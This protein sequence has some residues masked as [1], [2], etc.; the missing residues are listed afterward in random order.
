MRYSEKVCFRSRVIWKPADRGLKPIP[1]TFLYLNPGKPGVEARRRGFVR[2][3]NKPDTYRPHGSR[4]RSSGLL[5]LVEKSFLPF[6]LEIQ[7][8]MEFSLRFFFFFALV[9]LIV[10]KSITTHS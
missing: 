10:G 7:V 6:I 1:I 8:L 5:G 4:G 3:M 2:T 9:F